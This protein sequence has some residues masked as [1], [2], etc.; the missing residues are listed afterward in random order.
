MYM[1]EYGHNIAKPSPP[2]GHCG[3]GELS[4]TSLEVKGQTE[5]AWCRKANCEGSMCVCDGG[6]GTAHS[7]VR[8]S[9]TVSSQPREP[10]KTIAAAMP[11]LR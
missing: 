11:F 7:W 10:T 9:D 8:A 3:I 1:D 2:S 5:Q 4:H 6:A